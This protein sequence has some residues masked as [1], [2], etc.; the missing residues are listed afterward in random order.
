MKKALSYI[1]LFSTVIWVMTFLLVCAST[2][3]RSKIQ[4]KS[5]ESADYL[6]RRNEHFYN[7]F[8]DKSLLGEVRFGDCSKVDQIADAILLNI[9]Y[10]VEPEYPLKS[11]LIDRYYRGEGTLNESYAKTVKAK[12]VP[13]MQYLRYW[14]GSLI[15]VR[16]LLMFFNLEQMK[17]FHGLM[18]TS[19]SLLLFFM[20]IKRG[21]K[22]EALCLGISLGAVSI[23]FVPLSLE[24]TWMFLLM[25]AS[26][27]ITIKF[28]DSL[29]KRE[30]IY[31]LFLIT[32]IL[33]SFFDFLTT[34]TLTL[35]IPLLLLVRIG[36]RREQTLWDLSLYCVLNWGIGYIASWVSKWLLVYFVLGMNPIPYIRHNFFMH[37]G[38]YDEMTA[39]QQIIESFRR[40]LLMLFPFGYGMVGYIVFFVLLV[41]GLFLAIKN[42]VRLKKNVNRQII[43]LYCMLGLIVYARYSIIRHHGWFHYFFTYRAQASVI[44]AACFIIL[45]LI[46][47]RKE[48]PCSF[49]AK[50][51]R[52]NF[53]A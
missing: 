16:P 41:I 10:H 14:H 26:S 1:L 25:L 36:R 38:S 23:W 46:E 27:I 37:L 21:Y 40:N 8:G 5:E 42:N 48:C 31:L 45:E 35:L 17:I 19:L 20:L 32:G 28:S 11:V 44:L 47:L 24:Y 49:S 12:T 9:A 6:M 33:T 13:N 3:P 52:K 39:M 4:R 2:I 34:E 43:I 7:V 30:C 53:Y 18:I 29:D 22:S 15:F 51:E 50:D